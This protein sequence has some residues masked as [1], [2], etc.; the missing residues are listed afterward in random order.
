MAANGRIQNDQLFKRGSAMSGAPT[1]IGIIQLARPVNAG[2]TKPNTITNPCTVVIWL[3]KCGSVTC[4]PGCHSS[5]R[6]TSD[7]KPPM[8]AMVNANTRYSVPM[9]L[10]LVVVSQRRMPLG[11]SS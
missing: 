2:I 7:I 11:C 6:I 10:W 9:S 4:K 3:K 8:I 5:A 1:I